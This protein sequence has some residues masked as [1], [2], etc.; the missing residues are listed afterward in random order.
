MADDKQ[1]TEEEKLAEKRRKHAAYMR[2]YNRK[3]KES[4]P[5]KYKQR[6]KESQ[7]RFRER[8][9]E[10]FSESLKKRSKKYYDKM[11]ATETPEEKEKRLAAHRARCK[12]W[13]ENNK[14]RAKEVIRRNMKKYYDADP[15][16]HIDRSR[17]RQYKLAEGSVTKE[18]WKAICDL[19]QNRCAYCRK[20][21]ELHQDHV[22]PL[23]KGGPHHPDNVVPACKSCNS[24]KNNKEWPRPVPPS[25]DEI[26]PDGQPERLLN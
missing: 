9:P 15:Q 6:L 18:E 21:T 26:L 4:D 23:S 11:K 5:E 10:R 3:L 12:K 17:R 13:Y 16:K 19:F 24:S 8:H 1:M 25:P 14:E 20:Q 7:A 22:I 2:E